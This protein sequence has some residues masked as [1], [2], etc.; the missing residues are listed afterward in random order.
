M[1]HSFTT[2]KQATLYPTHKQDRK[3][4]SPFRKNDFRDATPNMERK[5]LAKAHTATR[6]NILARMGEHIAT[7]QASILRRN[8]MH[9]APPSRGELCCIMLQYAALCV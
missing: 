4:K 2:L 7:Q 3:G 6:A 1:D 9:Y 8:M 5:G